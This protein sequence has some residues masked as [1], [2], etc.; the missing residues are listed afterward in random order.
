MTAPAVQVRVSW[1][2][3]QFDEVTGY[4]SGGG[5]HMI[6]CML[7]HEAPNGE[8]VTAPA[9]AQTCDIIIERQPEVDGQY[10]LAFPRQRPKRQRRPRGPVT[11]PSEAG[12][13]FVLFS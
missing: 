6:A 1:F 5:R 12:D 10:M 2:N 3:G 7:T 11:V 9:L 8:L 4:N 13:Q